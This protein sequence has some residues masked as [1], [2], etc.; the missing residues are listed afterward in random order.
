MEKIS[1][2]ERSYDQLATSKSCAHDSDFLTRQETTLNSV[3]DKLEAN[4]VDKDRQIEQLQDQVAS[5]C[6]TC[7][8]S[9]FLL[10][11]LGQALTTV[12]TVL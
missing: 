7:R 8:T 2:L 3:H 1:L 5:H 11:C 6:S 9:L 12:V 4:L 10:G